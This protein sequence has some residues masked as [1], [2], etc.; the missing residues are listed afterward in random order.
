VK[1]NDDIN[2]LDYKTKLFKYSKSGTQDNELDDLLTKLKREL[3]VETQGTFFPWNLSLPNNKNK[4]KFL[5]ILNQT[6]DRGNTPQHY[7]AKNGGDQN[8]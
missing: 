6:D 7:A 5:K 2:E 1:D 8:T 3:N 4:M